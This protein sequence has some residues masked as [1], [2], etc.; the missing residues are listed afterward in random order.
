LEGSDILAV[1]KVNPLMDITS[2]INSDRVNE[3]DVLLLEE[4]IYFQSVA[5]L[6]NNI[7]IVAKGPGVIFDGKSTLL[8]A[9]LLPDVVG[10]MI[11]SI[12]IRHYRASGILIEFGF[13]HRIVNN[14]I[15]N[16]IENGIEVMSSRDNLIWRNEISKCYDG[17]LLIEGSTNNWVIE[18]VATECYGD[19]FEAFLAPDSN[20]AFISN[21]AIRNRNNGL[22]IYGTNNLLMNNLLIDNGQGVIIN[23]GNSSVAIGNIIRGTRVG[24][25]TIF[26]GY[27]NHFVGGNNITCNRREG[28][29]N[30]G[31][32][33]VIYN[34][35][36]SYNGD[37]GILLGTTSVLNL[38]MNNKLVCNIPENIDDR[39]TDNYLIDNIEKACDPCETPSD[40]CDNYPHAIHKG[41]DGSKEGVDN[42]C[43]KVK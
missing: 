7:R 19:G 40:V 41:M 36:I 12:T 22:E 5:V 27:F 11:E 37:N 13:G 18:N 39:G 42:G 4:G 16:M 32:F 43:K 1:I 33:N 34:N 24:T 9:F 6:K 38:V 14:K 2:L 20:N 17:V 21:K 8:D 15:I 26:D 28:I 31:E 10:V 30:N 25:Y 29:E 23:E 3:G 35:K